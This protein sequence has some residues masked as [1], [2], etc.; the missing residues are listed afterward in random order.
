V[1]IQFFNEEVD[2]TLPH[3]NSI[4]LWIMQ[5]V[6]SCGYQV[7]DINLIFCSESKILSINKQFLNHDY[8]TDIISFP[9]NSGQNISG[10]IF[11][12][13]PTVEHNAKK[14]GQSF[15]DELNRV[16]VHGVLHLVGFNDKNQEERRLMSEKEDYWLDILK[17]S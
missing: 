16:I 1:A 14:F 3:R 8:Y 10:D 7:K 2:F 6:K 12:S 5:V 13:I 17:N 15:N 11:I 9:Y 4:K